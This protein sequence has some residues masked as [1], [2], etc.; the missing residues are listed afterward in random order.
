[1]EE[2]LASIKRVIADD[3][4]A[5]AARARRLPRAEAP[6]ADPPG[7][8]DVLELDDPVSDATGLMS[9]DAADASRQKLAALTALRQREE[10][11]PDTCALDAVV[12]DMLRPMLK[13]WLDEHLPEIV[14]ELVT[15]E[16]ARITRRP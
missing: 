8:D 12:R 13:D 14:E 6:P 3:G 4:A 7:D 5:A 15:R 16:I 1:M 10:S 9:S 2:I 11:A